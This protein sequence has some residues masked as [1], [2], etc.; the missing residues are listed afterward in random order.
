MKKYLKISSFIYYFKLRIIDLI[1]FL[2]K[3]IFDNRTDFSS[4][5]LVVNGGMGDFIMCT[6]LIF[7]LSLKNIKVYI[8]IERDV[9]REI[10]SCFDKK[11]F[12]LINVRNVKTDLL[13]FSLGCNPNNFNM[14]LNNLSIKSIGFVNSNKIKSNFLNFN[15]NDFSF[16]NHIFSNLQILKFLNFSN[17]NYSYLPIKVIKNEQHSPIKKFSINLSSKGFVR[18]WP[19]D[20][21][22]LLINMLINKYN[23]AKIFLIGGID[24]FYVAETIVLK[25]SKASVYNLCGK[26]KL[27]ETIEIINNSDFLIAGDSGI[28]HIGFLTDIK[29]IAL[30]GP[31]NFQNYILNYSNKILLSKNTSYCKYGV[32]NK[33]CSCNQF[34]SCSFLKDISSVEVFDEIEKNI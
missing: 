2:Q 12:S 15:S 16:E 21:Y 19:L 27:S 26:L 9:T 25:N 33:T 34:D 17:L 4:V 20:N 18:N 23:E 13:I 10:A 3:I 24:D 32:F 1:F 31:T 22:S 5:V 6:P 30:F 11:Y 28:M 8:K 14:I 29:T 7:N